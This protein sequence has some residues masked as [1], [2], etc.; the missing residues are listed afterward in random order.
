ML[1]VPVG[2]RCDVLQSS[3]NVKVH[4]GELFG[5][6]ADACFTLEWIPDVFLGEPEGC[7]SLPPTPISATGRK[8][9]SFYVFIHIGLEQTL[10]QERGMKVTAER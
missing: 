5:S 8:Q 10:L 3:E 7:L 2:L 6:H 9:G 1:L 4:S